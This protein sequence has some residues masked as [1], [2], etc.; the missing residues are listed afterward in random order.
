[1]KA[2]IFDR[3]GPPEVLYMAN[4]PKPEPRANEVLIKIAATSVS[5]ADWRMRKPSPFLAR[6][7][8]GILRPRKIN[9][10]GLELAG[11]VEAAGSETTRFKPGDAVFAFTGFTFGAYAEYIC[12]RENAR[13]GDG[14]VEPKPENLDF[15][16]AAVIPGGALTAL[17]FTR[18]AGIT[19]GKR[20][21]VYGASGNV[22]S[23]AVQ[24]AKHMGAI[25][26]GV[27]S[28][29]NLDMVHS[30]GA[31]SIIDYSQEDITRRP[32]KFDVVFDAVAKLSAPR[33]RKLLTPEGR[34]ISV[35]H[36][37]GLQDGDLRFLKELAQTGAIRPFI[38]RTYPLEQIVEAH[39]YAE[40]GHKRANV[41]IRI[42]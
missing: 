23:Y 35:M 26:T 16:Q 6:L 28:T 9:I 34:F 1:M 31:N 24:L 14:M 21:L 18:T 17:A 30:L 10:L 37:G 41:A 40:A 4:V 22:G 8:N 33:G 25:V 3:Y 42:S 29:A 15:R 12:L 7:M 19:S 11:T 5:T 27:T 2:V 38:D 13:A 32:Q 39:R 36:A 20:V